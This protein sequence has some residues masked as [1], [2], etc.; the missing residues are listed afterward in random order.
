MTAALLAAG[1]AGARAQEQAAKPPMYGEAKVRT[2]ITFAPLLYIQLGNGATNKKGETDQVRLE[3]KDL[4]QYRNG[5]SKTIRKQVY[6][7]SIGTGYAVSAELNASNPELYKIFRM[8]IAPHTEADI[9][10]KPSSEKMENL[11]T[12]GSVGGFELDAIYGITAV[13]KDEN[14]DAFN[15][16]FGNDKQPKKHSIDITYTV[17]PQ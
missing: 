10:S 5:Y 8:N 16:L 17:L 12:G 14:V 3:L 1:A 7:Y 2:D 11:V 4:E 13:K 15:K 9:F 6:V